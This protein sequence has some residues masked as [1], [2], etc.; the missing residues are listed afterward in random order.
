MQCYMLWIGLDSMASV[1]V[2]ENERSYVRHR[3]RRDRVVAGET[4]GERLDAV[5]RDTVNSKR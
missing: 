1:A 2:M 5:T 4:G 3:E